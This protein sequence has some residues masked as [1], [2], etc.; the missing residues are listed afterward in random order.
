[1]A[2]IETLEQ[3]LKDVIANRKVLADQ[4]ETQKQQAEVGV[5]QLG[6]F[7]TL[8]AT[9][10][11]TLNSP[12]VLDAASVQEAA[13]ATVSPTGAGSAANEPAAPAPAESAQAAPAV[14]SDAAA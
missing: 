13:N 5:A 4:L 7:D 3:I 14:A 2:Q 9:L 11:V 10:Q 12:A 6:K 1:M 8:I